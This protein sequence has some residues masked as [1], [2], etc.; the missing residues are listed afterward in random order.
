[1]DRNV[2]RAVLTGG[3]PPK[4]SRIG[5]GVRLTVIAG[6]YRAIRVHFNPD[7]DGPYA[8][9]RRLVSKDLSRSLTGQ[10]T[11]MVERNDL[12]LIRAFL[13]NVYE[14]KDI[15]SSFRWAVLGDE[16][17]VVVINTISGCPI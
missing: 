6:S 9:F 5:L 7:N 4:R 11:I 12:N 14:L 16:Q 13:L 3:A 17:S 8:R 15:Q 10:M 1:M 2:V